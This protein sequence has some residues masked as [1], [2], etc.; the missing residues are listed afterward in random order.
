MK[1]TFIFL[2]LLLVLSSLASAQYCSVENSTSCTVE[3][4]QLQ[5]NPI[6]TDAFLSQAED[7]VCIVYFYSE[8]CPHCAQVKPLIDSL[9][10]EYSDEI[11]LHRY[12]VS[13]PENIQLYNKLC[14]QRG[15][16][17]KKIPLVGINDRILIG[18]EQIRENLEDEIQRG[19]DMEEKTCPIGT[20]SCPAGNNTDSLLPKVEK[21]DWWSIIPV[22]VVAGLGDG[23]NPCAF[24]ILIFVMVF[25]Q[26]I[27]GSKRR[28][29][30]VT[31]T[32]TIALFITN[33][34]LGVLYFMVT[35]R[36]GF[37]DIMRNLVIIISIVA[38]LINIKDFFYYGKGVSLGI[39]KSTKKYLE[40]LIHKASV[41]ASLVLGVSVAILEAPCSVPIYLAVIEVLKNEGTSLLAV[42]PYILIY[43]LM[44]I[45]PLIV[46]ATL[47]YMGYRAEI[48]ERQTVKGKRYMKLVIGVLLLVLAALLSLGIF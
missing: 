46:L 24:V 42:M 6:E 12:D 17:G 39:P 23:V 34:L 20:S 16:S 36:I 13:E 47:V 7:K 3:D 19:K 15:Y 30:K 9:A 32:Y 29:A 18:E 11:H 37:P 27:S 14:T 10:D 38:G 5:M 1:R 45:L 25:L 4:D 35:T 2:F 22:I 28:V 40:S 43:N 33:I 26:S 31:L 48:F 41:P 44:F 21:L 8:T